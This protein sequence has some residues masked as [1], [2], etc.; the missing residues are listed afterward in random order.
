MTLLYVVKHIR[1]V[2]AIAGDTPHAAIGSDLD[3]GFGMESIPAELDTVT[4]L[5][6]IGGALK[7]AQLSDTD[8]ENT[9][10]GNWLR[11]LRAALPR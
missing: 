1:H 9:L 7:A 8:V 11:L 5:Q 2:C 6:K 10:G 3:G 4:D